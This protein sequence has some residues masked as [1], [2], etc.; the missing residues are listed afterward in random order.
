MKYNYFSAQGNNKW[1]CNRVRILIT[2]K[3]KICH[4]LVTTLSKTYIVKI[5]PEAVVQRCSIKKGLQSLSATVFILIKLQASVLQLY[6]KR[7]SGTS[8]FLWILRNF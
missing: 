8:V 2:G 5:S 3:F 6:Q 1:S 4:I 7:V